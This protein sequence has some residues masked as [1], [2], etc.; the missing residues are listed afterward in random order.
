MNNML[1]PTRRYAGFTLLIFLVFFCRSNI[2]SFGSVPSDNVRI[3][4]ERISIQ[5]KGVK[6]GELLKLI[7][8][9]T[10]I[11][12]EL[13]NSLSGEK[14]SVDFKEV[15]ILEG[16]KEIINTLNYA[17]IY[18]QDDAADKVIIVDSNASTMIPAKAINLAEEEIS[19]PTFLG[20]P[21]P[22][23]EE[24]IAQ[25][26]SLDKPTPGA[27]EGIAQTPSLNKPTPGAEEG[28]AQTPFLDKPT[29][30]VKKKGSN[31]SY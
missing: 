30:G 8:D 27:E 26:P 14:I 23:A 9:K 11:K 22:G 19:V 4:G 29:P 3:E 24:G 5:V 15:S 25:T 28:I 20:K 10:G 13:D 6:L 2:A 7:E 16:I 1:R 18:D 21:T 31:L 12:F 17:I